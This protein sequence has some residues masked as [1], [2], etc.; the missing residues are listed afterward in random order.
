MDFLGLVERAD[1]LLLRT[2][3]RSLVNLSHLYGFRLGQIV[4]VQLVDEHAGVVGAREGPGAARLRGVVVLVKRT[5]ADAVVNVVGQMDLVSA[6]QNVV[7]IIIQ[8]W[9]PASV[10]RQLLVAHQENGRDLVGFSQIFLDFVIS[11]AGVR[12]LAAQGMALDAD[13]AVV[14]KCQVMPHVF[15]HVGHAGGGGG[16]D[17]FK[18]AAWISRYQ[19]ER[20]H[21]VVLPVGGVAVAV[22]VHGDGYDAPL[23]QL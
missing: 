18:I 4:V 19:E 13:L 21:G 17:L 10:H 23:C 7:R 6:L 5:R 15:H 11:I 12:R 9:K 8:I 14:Y 20:V 16:I 2:V 22:A 1:V 3:Y